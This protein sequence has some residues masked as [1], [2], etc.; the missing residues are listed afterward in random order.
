MLNMK[1]FVIQCSV[2]LLI[3]FI[4]PTGYA[5][6]LTKEE[7]KAA[8]AYL[9]WSNKELKKSLKGLSAAQLNFRE[10]EDRWSIQDCLYHIAF[11]EGALRGALDG[12]LAAAPDPATKAGLNSTDDQIKNM[13]TSRSQKVKTAPPFEPLNTGIKSYEEAASTFRTKRAALL[14]LIKTTTKD[15]RNHIVALPFAKMDS[16]QFVLFIAGHTNR[17]TQQINEVKTVAGY[18]KS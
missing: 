16:Y 12:S 17:H 3:F 11:S 4:T 10:S 5:Q 18:P 6:G 14:D 1:K 2:W 8:I 13:I 7:R 15:M 9:K